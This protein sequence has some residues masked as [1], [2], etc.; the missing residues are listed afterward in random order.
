MADKQALR[1][2]L[3]EKTVH[4][5]DDQPLLHARHR[6]PPPV[7]FLRLLFFGTAAWMFTTHLLWPLILSYPIFGTPSPQHPCSCPN[8]V[9]Q[10]LNA[11]DCA[12][13]QA[14]ASALDIPEVPIG[15]L[16]ENFLLTI[17]WNESAVAASRQYASQPHLAGSEG[18]LQT[19]ED[20]LDLLQRELNVSAPHCPPIYPAGSIASRNATLSIKHCN[21]TNAWIDIYYPVLNTPL[22]RSLQIVGDDGKVSW[23]ADLEE[24]ADPADGDAL[25]YEKAVPAFHGLSYD[26]EAE[27]R[28]IYA[29]YGLK[30]DFD[31]LVE[32]GVNLTGS[33]VLT[34]YGGNFRGL[35]VKAAQELGAA[36]VLIY[37]D[38]RD[39]GTVTEA[40][41]YTAYPHGPARNPTAVQRGSVQYLSVYPGDPTTPGYPAY[42]NSTRVN[43]TNI[44]S[45]P[46]LPLSWVNGKFLL[47]EI[48]GGKNFTVKLVNHVDTKVTPIWNVMGVVPGHI[49]D[50]VI[51][52]G[53]HRDAWVLGATDPSSGTA[54]LHEVVRGLGALI[55]EGW[56]PLRTILIASWDAEEYG[57]VGSTEWGEDFTQ[58]IDDHV[59]SY[60]NIDSAVLGSRFEAQAS[61]LLSHFIRNTARELPHPTNASQS[62][63]NATRD[64][65]ALHGVHDDADA[66]ALADAEAQA[67]DDV[68][69][70]PL[71]ANSDFT[72]FVQRAGVTSLTSGFRS[73]R[74]DP[75]YHYHSIYDSERW[76]EM[77]GD[78]GFARH[79]SVAKL[80]GLQMI[81]L[82]D[83][84][85]IPFNT[86]H[87]AFTL[88]SYLDKIEAQAAAASIV[89]DFA[90][91]RLAIRSLQLASFVLDHEKF[92]A[93]RFLKDAL[94]Y[95]KDNKTFTEHDP[96]LC[97]RMRLLDMFDRRITSNHS[98]TRA[99]VF[100]PV[101][102]VTPSA[103]VSGV[104][105]PEYQD[106]LHSTHTTGALCSPRTHRGNDAWPR[107]PKFPWPFPQPEEPPT[108]L[109]RAWALVRKINKKLATFER[110]FIHTEGLREREWYR[111]LG[112]AP[113]RWSGYGGTPLP[114]LTEAVTIEKNATL[115]A[116]EA[117][118]LR[119]AIEQIAQRIRA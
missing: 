119:M 34:R 116:Y 36:G 96:D 54:A 102:H 22:E 105:T 115:V 20:F 5:A 55:R 103:A 73:T 60:I 78:P 72:V 66:R 26:G 43:G 85:V 48:N 70:L 90:P 87:Y 19:A 75:V 108:T 52:V 45:I 58:W 31:A 51:V 40:N 49:K 59:V 46:S 29:N 79:V 113:G 39:D 27:G 18:D 82:S 13:M 62:L 65:G 32:Q 117:E 9:H 74:S 93:E 64:E 88:A 92:A 106:T 14:V 10:V 23:T 30:S 57:L 3:P 53:N 38:L 21:D 12:A 42:E 95:P 114:G 37:S 99:N 7:V 76:Q 15:R 56:R 63:W 28:L 44:P 94:G 17:P 107:L 24:V 8:Q 84:L 4:R 100:G 61:P 110:G 118:R 101:A 68:G 83:S 6:R 41:N 33:I 25:S 86:T 98:A 16:A 89:A 71:G 1:L 67:A 81:R 69:V 47:D 77:Y 50:E 91:L 112:V 11:P 111:H 104:V 97:R 109:V 80:L 2:P 35:K